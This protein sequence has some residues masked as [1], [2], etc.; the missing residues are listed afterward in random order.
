VIPPIGSVSLNKQKIALVFQ[1]G[2]EFLKQREIQREKALLFIR[3]EQCLARLCS[4]ACMAVSLQVPKGSLK[5]RGDFSC[6]IPRLCCAGRAS[7]SWDRRTQERWGR[8]P[9]EKN[10]IYRRVCCCLLHKYNC[11][12][13]KGHDVLLH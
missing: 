4:P 2:L 11:G 10:V 1:E 7:C 8:N 12:M 3:R 13:E 5:A 9:S 6:C